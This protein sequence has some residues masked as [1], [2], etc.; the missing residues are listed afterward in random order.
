MSEDR[1][2][3]KKTAKKEASNQKGRFF[4]GVAVLT[5]STLVVK[6]IG[7]F[8]K[9]PMMKYL[10]E[11]GMGY[12]NSAYEIYTLFYILATAGLPVAVSIL[13]AE[14]AEKGHAE[15]I[16]RIFRVALGL[17]LVLGLAGTAVL[18]FGAGSFSGLIESTGALPSIVAISPMVLFICIASAVRGYFQGFQNMMPT[19]LSQMI[20]AGGKLALGL[21]LAV[22]AV[23]KG[24][25]IP[26]AA[27]FA[28]FGITVG[29]GL[30]M[31]YLLAA[32]L[33]EKKQAKDRARTESEVRLKG[34]RIAKNIVKLLQ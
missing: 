11:E 18:Y 9:I 34:G 1:Y 29:S 13:V 8:Y 15:G 21:S 31:L 12:F 14:N 28:T 20:E 17:F 33:F 3:D 24:Y 2:K 26:E 22:W 4:S 16:K 6:L 23:K 27:A 25:G 32:K 19:A 10:G 7:L 30:S 5:L